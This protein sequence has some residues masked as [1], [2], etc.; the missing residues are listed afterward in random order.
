MPSPAE[1]AVEFL[2][3]AG[4]ASKT[5]TSGWVA[6]IGRLTT[7]PDTQVA[8]VDAPGEPSDPRWLLDFPWVTV[9]VRGAPQAYDT[10][11][12]KAKD[13]KDKLLGLPSQDVTGGRWNSVRAAGDIGFV[14]YDESNRPVFSMNFR[15]IVEPNT[16]VLANRQSL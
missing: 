4:I 12:Q 15:L 16:S 6:R 11:F 1:I 13:V 7:G 5:A 14:H 9:L 2:H 8:C 10:A 3:T